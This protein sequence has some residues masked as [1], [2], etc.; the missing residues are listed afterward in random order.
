MRP[1]RPGSAARAAMTGFPGA[2]GIFT[3]GV[4]VRPSVDV[5]RTRS[6]PVQLARCPQSDHAM[7]ATPPAPTSTLGKGPERSWFDEWKRDR[8]TSDSGEKLAPPSRERTT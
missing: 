6:L 3:G 7:Y 8:A 4:Q 5:E 2:S 1:G